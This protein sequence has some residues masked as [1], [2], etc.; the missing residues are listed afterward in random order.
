MAGRA[1]KKNAPDEKRVN[2]GSPNAVGLQQLLESIRL[3]R[4]E[5]LKKDIKPLSCKKNSTCIKMFWEKNV[6]L[7]EGTHM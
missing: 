6:G 4:L 3:T 2:F 7:A 1:W 5:P